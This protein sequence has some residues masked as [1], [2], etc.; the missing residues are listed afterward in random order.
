MTPK[1]VIPD[2]LKR[3]AEIQRE[4]VAYLRALGL[5]VFITSEPRAKKSS[6]NIWDLYVVNPRNGK[7]AWFETKQPGKPLTDGQRAFEQAHC[8][9]SVVFAVGQRE[10]AERLAQKLGATP[11]RRA[12]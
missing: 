1:P 5:L 12:A 3:E 6:R 7:T 10:A 2:H 8:R 4:C 11:E 9:N